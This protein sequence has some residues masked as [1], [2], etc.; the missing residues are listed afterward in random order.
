MSIIKYV[1]FCSFF[2]PMNKQSFF[3]AF[4]VCEE[5][6]GLDIILKDFS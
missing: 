5:S 6:V 2:S 4:S 3:P 1:P